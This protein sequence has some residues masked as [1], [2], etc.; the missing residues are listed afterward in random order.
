MKKERKRKEEIGEH[1]LETLN[2]YLETRP[3]NKIKNEKLKGI[4][5]GRLQE[6]REHFEDM[7]ERVNVKWEVGVFSKEFEEFDIK[8]LKQVIP[9]ILGQTNAG[10]ALLGVLEK[11]RKEK[12]EGSEK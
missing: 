9:A 12:A 10:I 5:E 8:E 6:Q 2:T 1:G 11:K 4:F 3:E 7:E